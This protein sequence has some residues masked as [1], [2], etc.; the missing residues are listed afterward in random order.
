LE[1]SRQSF[2]DLISERGKMDWLPS[3]DVEGLQG[4][5]DKT[6]CKWRRK[7]FGLKHSENGQKLI[8]FNEMFEFWAL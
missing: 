7:H 6:L 3:Q 8:V 5:E 2:F 4:Q 1:K